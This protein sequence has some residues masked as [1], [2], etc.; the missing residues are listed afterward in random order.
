MAPVPHESCLQGK[1][2]HV[3]LRSDALQ[4]NAT[5]VD[6]AISA[7]SRPLYC[8]DQPHAIVLNGRPSSLYVPEE[9]HSIRS[10]VFDRIGEYID[11]HERTPGL[12]CSKVPQLTVGVPQTE[13]C[14]ARIHTYS[15]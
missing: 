1:V 7:R 14:L 8:K 2:R 12:A 11:V 3:K 10:A 4:F 13:R 5:G 6:P 9:D 15:E